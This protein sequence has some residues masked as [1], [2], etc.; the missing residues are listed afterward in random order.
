MRAT[1]APARP[2]ER[3]IHF[4]LAICGIARTGRTTFAG[5]TF[6]WYL[7]KLGTLTLCSATP[8]VGYGSLT[9]IKSGSN[10]GW[11]AFAN[12]GFVSPNAKNVVYRLINTAGSD[13]I[14]AVAP[15]SAWTTSL[16]FVSNP[17]R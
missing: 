2:F 16:E 7:E 10:S 9:A 6:R 1:T 17:A 11:T 4:I 14:C 3:L 15:H 13:T 5:E 8:T 12:T